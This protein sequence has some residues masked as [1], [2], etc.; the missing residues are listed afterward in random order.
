MTD[1][2]KYT[3][4]LAKKIAYYDAVIDFTNESHWLNPF[5]KQPE[6]LVILVEKQLI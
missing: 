6:I 5:F 1:L 2:L 3:K 4:K